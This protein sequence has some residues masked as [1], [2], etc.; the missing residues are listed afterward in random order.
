MSNK[1]IFTSLLPNT[2]KEDIFLAL[3]LLFSP[4]RWQ[5]GKEIKKLE[6]AFRK[7]FQAKYSVSFSSGRTALWAILKSLDIK[8][9]DE[10][11]LQAYTCVVVPNA[12][13][14]LGAKPVWVDID[15]DTF[16]MDVTNLKSKISKK[17]KVIIIQH[18]FGQA[19]EIEEI[20]KIAKKHKL[21]VIEDCA[22]SLGAEY[23]KKR[24]GTFGEAAFFSFGRDKVISSV[25]G[26]LAIANNKRVG[27]RLEEIQAKLPFPFPSWIFQQLLHPL[28]F[29]VVVST[30]R[31]FW[32]GKI[33][34][35]LLQQINLLSRAVAKE[36]KMGQMK[37]RLFTRL[38][39]ALAA[40]ALKQ[41]KKLE[42]FNKRRIKIAR[43]YEKE[44]KGL[45]IELPKIKKDCHHIFLRYTIKTE[46]P[47]GLIQFAK[48]NN[49]FLGDWYRPVIAPKGTDF[50]KVFYQSGRCPQ[51]EKASA[52]SVNL[53]TYPKMTLRDAKRVVTVVKKFFQ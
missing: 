37:P 19:A 44:L 32:I 2:E 1:P 36:E 41:F 35:F 11:L 40:L 38:P 51:A 24:L 50:K 23:Q 42:S 26:G 12:I 31:F 52:R 45:P 7:Y 22:Q 8:K 6:E 28:V 17:A 14:S 48:K 39:N 13:T 9:D 33:F 46:K 47:E 30:Y 27:K 5:K 49:I 34:H 18:T 43:F 53:P 16:N 10:V 21:F 3:R 25:F 15:Q 4:S 29:S 20:K